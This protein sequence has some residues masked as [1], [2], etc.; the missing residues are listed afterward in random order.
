MLAETL[1]VDVLELMEPDETEETP[2][3]AP[4]PGQDLKAAV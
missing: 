3:P 4:E 2:P 1:G